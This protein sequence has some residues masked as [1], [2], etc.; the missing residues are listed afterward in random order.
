MRSWRPGRAGV[1]SPGGL[2]RR[3]LAALALAVLAYALF[4]AGVQVARRDA[5]LDGSMLY[6]AR[7]AQLISYFAAAL[8]FKDGLPSMRAME[9]SAVGAFG[10]HA[11]LYAALGQEEPGGALEFLAILSNA[12]SGAANAL[13][14][15]VL[16]HLFSTW[17]PKASAPAIALAVTL[18]EALYGLSALWPQALVGP[19]QVWM[20]VAGLALMGAAIAL[21]GDRPATP[22]E[23]P[24]QYGVALAGGTE[25]GARPIRFLISGPEWVF[26]VFLAILVPLAYGFVSQMLSTGPTSDGLQDAPSEAGMVAILAVVTALAFLRGARFD[27]LEMFASVC[28]LYATGFALLV[29]QWPSAG[30]PALVPSICLRS[31]ITVY[32]VALWSLLARKAFE[33]PRRTYLYFGVFLGVANVSYGRLLEPMV[34]GG[35]AIDAALIATVSVTFLW[36]LVVVCL[37]LFGL[38]RLEALRA[39]RGGGAWGSPGWRAEASGD[40]GAAELAGAE[41]AS[42]AGQRETD[43]FAAAIGTLVSVYGITPRERDVLVETLHGYSMKNAAQK[44]GISPETVRTH[45][46][47]VY[48]KTGA[49]SK[50]ALIRLIDG[51]ARE[52]RG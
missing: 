51:L 5:S 38:Q 24:L 7:Y 16:M 52:P 3:S 32:D 15:L 11:L 18:T 14:T 22:V 31:V 21:K 29:A 26:Q 46:R 36:L 47:N 34:L 4:T 33:D 45:L 43:P 49:Q 28:L 40:A 8:A 42:P 9:L 19:A 23:H 50:Q 35:R 30:G 13:V 10:L 12:A 1:P 17:C 25:Q 6:L 39:G 20:R 41:A 2:P 44:L 37:M 27:F 48:A